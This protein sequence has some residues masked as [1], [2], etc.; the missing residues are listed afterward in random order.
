VNFSR[1]FVDRPIFAGVLSLLI[2]LGGLISLRVLPI[3]EYRACH[4][5][6]SL[7]L[8]LELISFSLWSCLVVLMAQFGGSDDQWVV[9]SAGP[10][11]WDLLSLVTREV[12]QCNALTS[13]KLVRVLDQESINRVLCFD[14]CFDMSMFDVLTGVVF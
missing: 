10:Q 9:T 4:G 1:F 7:S 3:A 13:K 2:L 6:L 14:V 12:I 11:N 5:Y 8:S